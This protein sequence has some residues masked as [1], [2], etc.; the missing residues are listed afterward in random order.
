M[1]SDMEQMV[2]WLAKQDYRGNNPL[3]RA[4]MEA[5]RLLAEGFHNS[6]VF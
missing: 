3:D 6:L 1:K 5:R 2:E 4:I